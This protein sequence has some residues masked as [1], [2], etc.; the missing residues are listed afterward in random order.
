VVYHIQCKK[1]C[2]CPEELTV[3]VV[4]SKGR[5]EEITV[6]VALLTSNLHLALVVPC[7]SGGLQEILGQQ[8]SLFVEIIARPL[9]NHQRQYKAGPASE[10][11]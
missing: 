2:L 6:V 8:L 5:Y 10:H 11:T 7:I 3:D 1:L 4:S 9:S